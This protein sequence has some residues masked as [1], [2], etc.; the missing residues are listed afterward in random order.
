MAFALAPTAAAAGYRVESFDTIGSTNA[1]ALERA[2]AGG[3]GRTWFVSK[4]Q[5]S[6]RGRRG[7]AWVAADGNLAA[8]LLL[9]D[10]CPLP[11]AA[12]L[13]FVAGLAMGEALEATAPGARIAIGTDGADNRAARMRFQL[14]WPNDVLAGGA[15][16]AGILLESTLLGDKSF[17]V[18]I[19]IGVNVVDHPRD[20]PFPATSLNALGS[21]CDAETLFLALSDAWVETERLWDGGRGLA[22]IRNRWIDRAAGLGG[23][24]AVRIDG[25]IVRGTFATIDADCHF[26]LRDRHGR[27][28]KIAAGDVHFG[29]IASAAAI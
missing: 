19:G 22:A 20:V 8:T 18:A 9:V 14:K 1:A 6:G 11:V 26:V 13:G 29:A 4:R 3:A 23:E 24:V 5:E 17:A 25:E 15:K 12:T 2:R 21:E 7:R 10:C 16:L 28:L 27:Q